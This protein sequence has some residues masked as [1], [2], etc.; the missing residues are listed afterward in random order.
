MAKKV[1]WHVNFETGEPGRCR[2][3]FSNPRSTGCKFNQSKH[4]H[5]GSREEAATYYEKRQ[6]DLGVNEFDTI[7]K[8]KPSHREFLQWVKPGINKFA[9]WGKSFKGK[10]FVASALTLTALTPFVTACDTLQTTT[11]NAPVVQTVAASEYEAPLA[12]DPGV[13]KKAEKYLEYINSLRS[14][15]DLSDFDLDTVSAGGFFGGEDYSTPSYELG[16]VAQFQGRNLVPSPSEVNEAKQKLQEL[17]LVNENKVTN[18]NREELFGRSFATGVVGKIEHRDAPGAK[19][20]NSEPQSR[21]VTG[22]FVDPYT[23][24]TVN[25]SSKNNNDADLDHIVPLKEV[26]RSQNPDKPL[27]AQQRSDIANDFDNLQLVSATINREKSDK[28]PGEWLPPLKESRQRYAIATIKVKHKY[29]LS[30]DGAEYDTLLKLL[31]LRM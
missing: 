9:L 2:A 7:S 31:E 19:F 18:Y 26:M 12:K 28:D 6:A 27:T 10:G 5:F 25:I 22:S 14:Y 21:A 29:D 3:D 13:Q 8:V 11:A 20:K 17:R 23:G 24:E 1:K 4:E 30:V 16:E 15:S